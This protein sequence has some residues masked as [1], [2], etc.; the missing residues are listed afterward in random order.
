MSDRIL[1]ELKRYVRQ[2]C[3]DAAPRNDADL[4]RQFIEANDH[5]AFEMLLE[6]HGPMVL[7]TARRLV[8]NAADA[9]DVFQAVFLSLARLAKTI[10]QGKTVPNWLYT[11]TC[12]LAVRA[13]KRRQAIALE[14][15]PEPSIAATVE[16]DLAWRE[17]QTALDEELH[18]R[19]DVRECQ[20]GLAV[21]AAHWIQHSCVIVEGCHLD[22]RIG[23]KLV[24]ER[25]CPHS[26]LGE[27]TSV[28][29]LATID[30]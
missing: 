29:A 30:E 22:Q 5:E 19:R 28:H 6:R 15:A 14:H 25:G 26:R 16:S 12:R 9:D 27:Q 13:R 24:D 23:G 18:D 17:V 4:L 3:D 20:R 21:V 2:V 7:G 10:R 8:N 11:T 1:Q